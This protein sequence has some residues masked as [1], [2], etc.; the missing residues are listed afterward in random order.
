MDQVVSWVIQAATFRLPHFT[1]KIVINGTRRLRRLPD[2]HKPKDAPERKT[3][4]SPGHFAAQ[5]QKGLG[6]VCAGCEHCGG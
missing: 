4:I 6:S 3:Q 5:G 2:P 1:A